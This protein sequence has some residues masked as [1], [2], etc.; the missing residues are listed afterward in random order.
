MD[1]SQ[2]F[3][4]EQDESEDEARQE[5]AF[6]ASADRADWEKLIA[7]CARV[8]F[9]AGDIVLKQGDRTQALFIVAKG[10]L[11]VVQEGGNRGPKRLALIPT[12]SVF[13]EQAFF[14]GAP[15]SAS[16]RALADGEVFELTAA[17]FDVLAAHEPHL[18]R[19]ILFD[20]GRILSLRLRETTRVLHSATR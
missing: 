8:T 9:R 5:L 7:H 14:D 10:D 3:E 20:L 15:R 16:V 11:E 19:T 4:Y 17:E 18:A 1:F 6:L 12:G 13:G 2:F